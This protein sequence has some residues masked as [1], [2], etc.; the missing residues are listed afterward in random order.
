MILA[1]SYKNQI[2]FVWKQK[3]IALHFCMMQI[4]LMK[5]DDNLKKKVLKQL[6]N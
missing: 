4:N 3:G 5:F 2:A 6:S 1:A